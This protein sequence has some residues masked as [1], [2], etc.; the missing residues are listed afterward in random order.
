MTI[1]ELSIKRPTLVVVIFTALIV[2]GLFSYFQLQYELLP[3]MS[4]PWVSVVTV[5]P[6]ASPKVVE[7]TVSKVI[8]DAVSTM[9]KV[10]NVYATSREGVSVVSIEFV[11]SADI[12]QALPD[13]QR[14]VNEVRALLP[15]GI[16][17]PVISK[18]AIDELPV[19]RIGATSS[20]PGPAF[21]QFLKDNVQPSLAKL[22]GVGQITFLGMEEREI[23]VNVD[24][25]RLRA[26]NLP[27]L[28]VTQAIR[29]ANLEFPTGNVKDQDRQFVVRLAGKIGSLEELRRLVIGKSD[30][31]GE[32][33]LRDV[34]EVQ[35]T[36]REPT[37]ITR[38]NGKPAVGLQI[39]KQNDANAVAVSRLV[40]R[41]LQRLEREYAGRK[42]RFDVSQDSSTFTIN[43]ADAVKTDLLWAILLVGLVMLVF[44]TASAT[45]SSSWWPFPAR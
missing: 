6:G 5:Y 17:E 4:V 11:T 1:T 40:R 37:N 28:L 36:V 32:I 29:A 12:N 20:L 33:K 34:A 42:L 38:L 18:F 13:A 35:D 27:L 26:Y 45:R 2:L 30:Q 41:E 25:Q 14:K 31:G 7:T 24:R 22:G 16:R 19:L 21:A 10:K 15:D 39:Q 43:A 9:D 3:K 44:R 8:E 23:R